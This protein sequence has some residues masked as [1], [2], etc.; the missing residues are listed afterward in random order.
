M[1]DLDIKREFAW[2]LSEPEPGKFV[3][4]RM[5]NAIALANHYG[6]DVILATATGSVPPWLYQCIQ[7]S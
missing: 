4:D 1:S 5:D 7:M 6:I 2:A 3:F